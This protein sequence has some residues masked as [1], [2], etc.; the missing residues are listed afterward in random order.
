MGHDI[1]V[2][3]TQQFEISSVG[4]TGCWF[5]V[6]FGLVIV[7]WF[8]CTGRTNHLRGTILRT[9]L[10]LDVATVSLPM[11]PMLTSYDRRIGRKPNFREKKDCI[12]QKIG[13]IALYLSFFSRYFRITTREFAWCKSR[14]CDAVMVFALFVAFVNSFACICAMTQTRGR[15]LNPLT[16]TPLIWDLLLQEQLCIV[17]K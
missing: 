1:L 14:V 3:K 8:L 12:Y 4:N 13:H 2:S 11:F 10:L 7:S 16:N 17:S 6:L 5:G 9:V 15:T